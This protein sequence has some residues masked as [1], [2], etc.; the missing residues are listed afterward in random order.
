MKICIIGLGERGKKHLLAALQA[1]NTSVVAICDPR[2]DIVETLASQYHI[3]GYQ[4]ID[5]LLQHE[6]PDIAIVAVPH[7]CYMPI[8]KKLVACRIHILKEKPFA[9]SLEEA[10]ELA[11]LLKSKNIHMMIAC[12][13]RFDIIYQ[14]FLPLLQQIGKLYHIDGQYLLNI[15]NL[16]EGWR[17][18][19]KLSGGGAL[20]DM[21]YHFIDLLLWYFGKPSHIQLQKTQGHRQGQQYDVEDTAVLTFDYQQKFISPDEKTIGHFTISRSAH[22]TQEKI[23]ARGSLG[24]VVLKRDGIYRFNLKG[25]CIAHLLRGSLSACS[26]LVLQLEHFC[27]YLRG[28]ESTLINNFHDHMQHI[29]LITTA[30]GQP[31]KDYVWPFITPNTQKAVISQLNTSISIYDRSGI[32]KTFEDN[33][34]RYHD[35]RYA[36]MVNSGTNAIFAAYEALNLKPGDEVLVPTYTFFAT[37]SPLLYLGLIP[38]FCDCLPDGNINPD[39]IKSKIGPKTKALMITHMWG[40]PCDM[41]K[42]VKIVKTHGLKLL[43][44]CSHAHG[45]RYHNQLVGTFGDIALWSLQGQKIVTGGEGGILLTNDLDLYARAQ[46]QGQYNKRCKQE[47]PLTHPLAKF[48]L[49]GFGLK[50]RAHPLAAAI[51]NEQFSHLDEWLRMKRIYAEHIINSLADIPFL[52]PPTTTNKSPAWYAL[53]FH[54]DETHAP[55]SLPVFLAHLQQQGLTEMERPNSTCPIHNL[56]LFTHAHEAFPRFYTQ[57]FASTKHAFPIADDYFK[58]ALKMPVWARLEDKPIVDKYIQGI[59]EVALGLMDAPK[60]LSKL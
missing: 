18:D 23:T 12:Q 22:K 27:D 20:L 1:K 52:I 34:S 30:Y 46:L 2:Q 6:K 48:S 16:D 39:E 9:T 54:Y 37:V 28:N 11:D 36:L 53:V 15:Q 32:I 56:P 51:A 55:V 40:I 50:T 58:H 7:H 38:V 42:I 21:G 14:L 57:G 4:D 49:T 45:A 24:T 33:F 19:K 3:K 59:R 43:E 47:I 17:A 44:D 31:Q 26:S 41:D 13:R 10:H 5:T 60:Y 35:R 25:E 29:N 8:I